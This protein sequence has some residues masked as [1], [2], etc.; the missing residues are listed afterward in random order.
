[1]P[2]AW[3]SRPGLSPLDSKRK[4]VQEWMAVAWSSQSRHRSL[5][6]REEPPGL[7]GPGSRTLRPWT[8]PR[9][10]GT[11]VLHQW[12]GPGTGR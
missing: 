4:Q 11:G 6:G 2:T 9:P 12:A 7:S 3:G 8:G 1:M 10:A 5:C